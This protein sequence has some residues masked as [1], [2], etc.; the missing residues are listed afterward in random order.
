[1]K[2]HVYTSITLVLLLT[3]GFLGCGDSIEC[4]ERTKS[5]RPAILMDPI[6]GFCGAFSVH[7][8]V[9][10]QQ[11]VKGMLRFYNDPSRWFLEFK[12]E[13]NHSIE[14]VYLHFSPTP[15]FPVDAKQNPDLSSFA[16]QVHFAHPSTLRRLNFPKKDV[17]LKGFLSICLVYRNPQTLNRCGMGKLWVDGIRYGSSERGRYFAYSWKN[18][19]TQHPEPTIQ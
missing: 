3:S 6:E 16:H 8:L 13:E 10:V 4:P 11:E 9:T 17:P 18:C 7:D 14:W 12:L 5:A 2:T 19:L 1:M 15:N